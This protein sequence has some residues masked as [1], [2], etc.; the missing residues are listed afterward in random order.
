MKKSLPPFRLGKLPPRID[1][2][3]LQLKKYLRQK[4]AHQ[5]TLPPPPP[6]VDWTAKISS[7]PMMANGTIG[8]CTCAAAGHMIECWTANLGDVFTPS[9]AQIIAAYS[10]VSGYVTGDPATDSGAVE[11]DVL[12]YWRQKGIAGHKIDAYAAIDL[13]PS[14]DNTPPNQECVKQAISLFGGAY[15]GLALPLSSQQQ[16]VWDVPSL[17]SRLR[18]QDAPGSWGGHAVP[19]LVYDPEGLTCITWGAKKRMTWQFFARYC[20]EAYAPL[21]RDWLNAQGKN[22]EGLDIDALEADLREIDESAMPATIVA[23]N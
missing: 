15:I 13:H 9:N 5:R 8:D 12:N 1:A 17:W 6:S 7:W 16:T 23:G 18:N 22:P 14:R 10:A 2:R 4:T 19:L 3:T 11:L 20:D 21:S